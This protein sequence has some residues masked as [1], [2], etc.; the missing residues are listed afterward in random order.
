MTFS[1][2]SRRSTWP[3][4]A[5]RDAVIEVVGHMSRRFGVS[6]IPSKEGNVASIGLH[7][8]GQEDQS[9]VYGIGWLKKGFQLVDLETGQEIGTFHTLSFALEAMRVHHDS[10]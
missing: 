7:S 5:E 2:F 8:G 4:T 6:F 9:N 3:T 1:P 10:H